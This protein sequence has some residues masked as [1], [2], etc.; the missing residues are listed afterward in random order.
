MG[1][2]ETAIVTAQQELCRQQQGDPD[3]DGISNAYSVKG[4]NRNSRVHARLIHLPPTCCKLSLGSLQASDVGKIVQCSGN[5]VRTTPVCMYESVRYFKVS[6]HLHFL[7]R[8][9]RLF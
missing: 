3:R 4:A 9:L 6:F 1:C 5:V 2:L 7:I 8:W